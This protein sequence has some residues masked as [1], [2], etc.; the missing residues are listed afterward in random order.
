M[1][2]DR[3]FWL[4]G[5]SVLTSWVQRGAGA[6]GNT[7][8]KRDSSSSGHQGDTVA[9]DRGSV[10]S[11]M[12]CMEVRDLGMVIIAFVGNQLFSVLLYI[13][14][15]YILTCNILTFLTLVF[16]NLVVLMP[17]IAT[18]EQQLHVES[19]QGAGWSSCPAGG[20]SHPLP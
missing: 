2:R 10:I 13:Y 20:H 12:Q 5:E 14:S 9:L 16:P 6:V 1:D 3:D 15:R 8:C 11:P 18:A 19:G 7:S 4:L 17:N